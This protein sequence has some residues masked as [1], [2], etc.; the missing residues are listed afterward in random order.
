MNRST[1]TS[2]AK[3]ED[4]KEKLRILGEENA[5]LTEQTEDVLLLSLIF[6]SINGIE[7]PDEILQ[8]A[9]E[10]TSILKDIPLC[11]CASIN[12]TQMKIIASSLTFTH[13]N[14][15]G[16]MQPV[17][18]IKDVVAQKSCY[19]SGNECNKLM[20]ADCHT[21]SDFKAEELL[22]ISFSSQ[23]IPSGVFLFICDDNED[24]RI[25]RNNVLLHQVVESVIAVVD[26]F[27]LIQTLRDVNAT[28]DKRV[29]ERTQQLETS[30]SRYRTLLD[31]S[32]AAIMNL[33]GQVFT[34]CNQATLDMFGVGQK[35]EFLQHSPIDFSPKYQPDGRA[36]EE[37]AEY[38]M[39]IALQEGSCR[40]EWLH[41]RLDETTFFA[42]VFLS[43]IEVGGHCVV[44]GIATD[45]SERK[46]V[47]DVLRMFYHAAEQSADHVI[48]INSDYVIEYFNPAACL[49]TGYALGE[50]IGKVAY[51]ARPG[52]RIKEPYRQL[53]RTV[54]S[55]S[56]WEG[57]LT[58]RRKNGSSFPVI[59]SMTVL[60]DEHG[61]VTHYVCIQK[62]ITDY[63]NLE[64]QFRQAQKMDVLGTFVGGIA[65]NFNNL[66][67]G[68]IG[69]ADLL[70]ATTK[71]SPDAQIKLTNIEQL[72]FDAADIIK[73]LLAF[74]R[75]STIL[76]QN[77]NFVIFIKEA[78][79]LYDTSLAEN[80]GFHKTL[81]DGELILHG[82]AN[83][84]QQ[85]LFNLLNNARDALVNRDDPT[86]HISLEKFVADDAF[87]KA[88]P[89]IKNHNFAHLSISDNGSGISRENVQNIFEPFFTTKSVG[90]GTGLGLAMVYGS[91]HEHGGILDVQSKEGDGTCMHVY[92]P[93]TEAN[94]DVTAPMNNAVP[95]RGNGE[96]ILL[97]DDSNSLRESG[98]RLLEH[99]GYKVLLAED[100]YDAMAV[101]NEHTDAID[102]VMMDIVMPKM[103]GVEAANKIRGVNPD[104][105]VIFATGYDPK[106][107]MN[108]MMPKQQ[109]ILLQ[110]PFT[111]YD[112]SRVV[113]EALNK[114]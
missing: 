43:R 68:I 32:K 63:E 91:I 71:H 114:T 88:Y 106:S 13:E 54:E 98:K 37:A 18:P 108:H 42:E 17:A 60:R 109:E 6:E 87:L 73:Q 56:S 107:D 38:Y 40:F 85:V 34:E 3:I 92:L 53:W 93:L 79:K 25:A 21:L 64:E 11:A 110:K 95:L 62:D 19:L 89:H 47:E 97:V 29:E 24:N 90:M 82:N 113:K 35:T 44:Q 80:I 39:N 112:L 76:M 96:T 100:G 99:L 26:K 101:F 75:K 7:D 70:K 65:H 55:K 9:L 105:P 15:N 111:I 12:A 48:I 77:F 81:T 49:G 84:L 23:F 102:L 66:L 57:K 14:I 50:A 69:N 46:Q 27:S 8:T 31:A 30:E 83:Q 22:I 4:L 20:W 51:F 59:C 33:D 1:S 67:A 61:I 94:E 103:G 45:I 10:R 41:Q 58:E 86:I 2:E 72:S 104:L 16:L 74:A 5:L 52:V 36:S 78:C 28:L